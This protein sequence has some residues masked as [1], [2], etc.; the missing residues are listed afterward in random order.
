MNNISNRQD[1]KRWP[2]PAGPST[3][4]R[5][6]ELANEYKKLESLISAATPAEAARIRNRVALIAAEMRDLGY[7]LPELI[8]K[9]QR[10]E[11]SHG[12]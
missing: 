4:E 9:R 2:A 11:E 6:I 3:R 5:A 7:S 12:K 1:N 10:K 8:K